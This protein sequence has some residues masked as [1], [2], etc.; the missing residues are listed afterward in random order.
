LSSFISFSI[1]IV[2]LFLINSGAF[3]FSLSCIDKSPGLGIPSDCPN[4][5]ELC[6]HPLYKELMADQCQLWI[7]YILEEKLSWKFCRS[8]G[9]CGTSLRGNLAR[10]SRVRGKQNWKYWQRE[11]PKWAL[12]GCFLFEKVQFYT[13]IPCFPVIFIRPYI[14]FIKA[15]SAAVPME[16]A[17]MG[18]RIAPNSRNAVRIPFGWV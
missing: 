1:V 18:C 8:C 17:Q 2:S 15:P 3:A 7:L 9:L 5:L 16:L 6:Q 11:C 12:L 10:T 14:F 13:L 4:R